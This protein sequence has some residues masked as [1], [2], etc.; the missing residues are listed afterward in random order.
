MVKQCISFQ[1]WL[2]W[3]SMFV[4]GGVSL[5]KMWFLFLA[6]LGII[7]CNCWDLPIRFTA[8]HF[9]RF[10]KQGHQV[11]VFLCK[12]I[13][14][15]KTNTTIMVEKWCLE[16]KLFLLYIY[17]YTYFVFLK[18]FSSKKSVCPILFWKKNTHTIL[19]GGGVGELAIFNSQ[20]PAHWRPGVL[21]V[22]GWGICCYEH[23]KIDWVGKHPFFLVI[24]AVKHLGLR[25]RIGGLNI[26]QIFV[27]KHI[28]S[29]DVKTDQIH[30]PF[31]EF[32]DSESGWLFHFFK[33]VQP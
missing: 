11:G 5:P 10:S 17:I 31:P 9:A 20:A 8:R 3:V 13:C 32:N 30:Q 12:E 16:D 1:I 21:G 6:G 25:P 28:R 14:T 2:F 7:L 29:R 19:Y 23:P 15:P 27:R 33:N 18:G 22:L 24:F 26:C 4:F